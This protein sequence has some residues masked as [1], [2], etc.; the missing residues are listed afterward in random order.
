ML[1]TKVNLKL[2]PAALKPMLKIWRLRA[3]LVA[4]GALDE[5]TAPVVVAG[6]AADS[7]ARGAASGASRGAGVAAARLAPEAERPSAPR[8]VNATGRSITCQWRCS[9]EPVTRYEL[10]VLPAEEYKPPPPGGKR[11]P[12]D[13]FDWRTVSRNI[14]SSEWTVHDLRS[15]A[16]FVMRA[17]ARV[18]NR[19]TRYSDVSKPMRTVKLCPERVQKIM[20]RDVTMNGMKVSWLPPEDNGSPITLYTLLC[21]KVEDRGDMVVLYSGATT[22]CEAINLQPQTTYAFRVIATNSFGDSDVSHVKIQRTLTPPID[23]PLRVIGVW[24]E[25]WDKSHNRSYFIN[26]E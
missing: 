21:G 3:Q 9:A 26:D 16:S 5:P 13:A 15:G 6:G 2:V 4:E 19:W 25:W 12:D 24:S 14:R 1:Q 11:K 8:Q 22:S 20:C 23:K 17:R 18:V 10:Q 7:A